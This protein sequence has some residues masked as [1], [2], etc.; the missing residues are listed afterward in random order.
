MKEVFLAS[1]RPEKVRAN[2]DDQ[3]KDLL[4]GFEISQI[5]E[6]GSAA[7]TQYSYRGTSQN[8]EWFFAGVTTDDVLADG[9]SV[10]DLGCGAGEVISR[11]VKRSSKNSALG[12]TANSYN[13]PQN[14]NIVIGNVHFLDTLLPRQEQKFDAVISKLMFHH[15]CDPLSVYETAANCVK[16]GG[17]FV[18]DTFWVRADRRTN[19]A[20]RII[21]YLVDGG[22]F[23][24]TGDNAPAV[25]KKYLG[26]MSRRSSDVDNVMPEMILR[27]TSSEH[28]QIILPIDYGKSDHPAG[29]TYI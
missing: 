24:V 8:Y 3:Y 12:I 16:Q 4:N 11:F 27:R 28:Q 9:H 18:S 23:E 15:L 14:P 20:A 25:T 29:W 5:Q 21:S 19:V 26:S 22:H 17:L 10:L 13:S 1:R 2:I 7:P 6:T